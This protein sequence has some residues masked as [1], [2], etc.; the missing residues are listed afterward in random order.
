MFS[1]DRQIIVPDPTAEYFCLIF[2]WVRRHRYRLV[3][4][5][6]F[7][8]DTDVKSLEKEL[9]NLASRVT[10]H[11][12]SLSRFRASARRYKGAITLYGILFYVIYFAVWIAFLARKTQD[13]RR[14]TIETLPVVGIPIIIYLLRS[15]IST[16]YDRRIATEE[17][18]LDSLKLQQKEKIEEFKT[19]TDFYTTKSL[20]DRYSN[21]END[22][23]GTP[24][25]NK[26]KSI[27]GSPV[28]GTKVQHG[29]VVSSPQQIQHQLHQSP[30]L[31]TQSQMTP[32]RQ[33]Q[34]LLGTVPTPSSL[35]GT[36]KTTTKQEP[37]RI[38]EFAPNAEAHNV[39]ADRHW[40][41]RLLDVVIGEDE[42]N[43]KS[44]HRLEQTIRT[45]DE[46]ITGL[47]LEIL[48][49]QKLVNAPKE[50]SD[51]P[52]EAMPE[53]HSSTKIEPIVV[54]QQASGRDDSASTAKPRKSNRRTNTTEQS[55]D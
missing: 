55:R 4:F 49:L 10:K 15:V 12:A 36:P 17:S 23:A 46:K 5:K 22:T 29:S 33:Q 9:A 16:Y 47:E 53:K 43:D 18:S 13:T 39:A 37:P 24:G 38:A 11:E 30:R 1:L 7:R 48:R 25:N 31:A 27:V 34:S 8:K 19:K 40:Y 42:G 6:W 54:E 2:T 44:R 52:A 26:S 35:S 32:Q 51:S 14:W 50:I 41:D 3:M 45:K 20:I 21:T 28:T